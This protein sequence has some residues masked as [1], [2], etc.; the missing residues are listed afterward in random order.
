MNKLIIVLSCFLIAV[1]VFAADTVVTKIEV[2][3]PKCAPAD[4]QHPMLN[5]VI[6]DISCTAASCQNGTNA[7]ANMK[8]GI[9]ELAKV[10]SGSGGVQNVGGGVRNMLSNALKET[11]CFNI[12]DTEQIEK[13]KKIASVTGQEI[14]I[15]KIDLFVDGSIT[16]ID[17]TRSGGALAGGYIPV[18][19]LVSKTKEQAQMAFDLSILNP[20]TAEVVDSKSFQADSSKSSWGFGAGGVNGAVGGG[21]WSISKSLVL[22]SVIRDVIFSIANHM[23][24]SFAADRIAARPVPLPAENTENTPKADE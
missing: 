10:F 9:S 12:V 4:A 14:K 20:M 6:N 17:V 2:P 21:G 3:V 16:S 22:D 1:P 5:V 23:T 13:L 19:A 18:I 15:P 11:K 24:E 8:G 7:G